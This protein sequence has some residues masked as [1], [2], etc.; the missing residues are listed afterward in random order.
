MY[1]MNSLAFESLV[2]T[3][4]QETCLPHSVGDR[5]KLTSLELL[6]CQE[7]RSIL[8]RV[9]LLPLNTLEIHNCRRLQDMESVEGGY[10]S[11]RTFFVRGCRLLKD[12][13]FSMIGQNRAKVAWEP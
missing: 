7:L 4:S 9:S 12:V 1:F 8:G 13:V 11:L 3:S 10:E 2:L 6:C 5:V